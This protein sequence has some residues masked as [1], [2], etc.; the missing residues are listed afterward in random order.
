MARQFT[1]SLV[2]LS[3][4]SVFQPRETPQGTK[5][6]SVTCLL[7]KSDKAGYDALM[8]AICEEYQANKD[9]VLKGIAKPKIPVH[10]GD[11]TTSTGAEFGP[12]C[13]GHWVFTASANETF[14]PSVVDQ[15][16][17]PIMN[18]TDVYSGCWGHVAISIYAYNNQSKG[19][20]FGLNGIQKVKDD[21]ALGFSFNA[22]DAFSTVEGSSDDLP[23]A[24][25]G[26]ID[27]LTGLP[28][29]E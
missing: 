3:Y 10:D 1:T 14:P 19:I 18:Q 25:T 21:E 2:R 29:V 11:G 23:F 6:Y 12:E 15:R 17:Q 27:P 9:T 4:V 7:P 26:E 13:K 20:G 16:V 22:S 5:K 28:I 8:K 24:K